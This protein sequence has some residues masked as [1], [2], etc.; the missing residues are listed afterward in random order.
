MEC[1][2]ALIV[3]FEESEDIRPFYCKKV[4]GKISSSFFSI[5]L[6]ILLNDNRASDD[7]KDFLKYLTNPKLQ[8]QNPKNFIL[9]FKKFII[10]YPKLYEND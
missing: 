7:F 1:L 3:F 10:E 2:A 8:I 5:Y 9:L 4:V 6:N